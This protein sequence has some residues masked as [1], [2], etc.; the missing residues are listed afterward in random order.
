MYFCRLKPAKMDFK[1][2]YNSF[3]VD[4][5]TINLK[6]LT[7]E[8]IVGAKESGRDTNG[9]IMN[10]VMTTLEMNLFVLLEVLNC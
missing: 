9:K 7:E 2:K 1:Q 10:I 6:N 4:K 3:F 8:F 5:N